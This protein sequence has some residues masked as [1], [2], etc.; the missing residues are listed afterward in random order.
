MCSEETRQKLWELIFDL[1]PPEEA[2]ALRGQ[3]TSDPAVARAYSEARLRA[4]L[5]AAA[6]KREE[7]KLPLD[8]PGA[9]DKFD[10]DDSPEVAAAKRASLVKVVSVLASLAALL[11]VSVGVFGFARFSAPWAAVAAKNEREELSNRYVRLKVT[12]S[13]T[14][15]PSTSNSISIDAM[16]LDGAPVSTELNVVVRDES[17][18][19]RFEEHSRTDDNGRANIAI[20]GDKVADN[21]VLNIETEGDEWSEKLHSDLYSLAQKSGDSSLAVSP[22]WYVARSLKDGGQP[23]EVD[24]RAPN[25]SSLVVTAQN[26]GKQVGQQA[27]TSN[28]DMDAS[29]STHLSLPLPAKVSGPTLLTF[30][31]S[32]ANP[33]TPLGERFF[34]VPSVH[35]LAILPIAPVDVYA[36]GDDFKLQFQV[37]GEGGQ[38][39]QA[40]LRVAV[41]EESEILAGERHAAARDNTFGFAF[42]KR[43]K[44]LADDETSNETVVLSY[45]APPVAPPLVLDN[46]AQVHT[47]YNQAVVEFDD[48][49]AARLRLFGQALLGGGSVLLVALVLLALLR[50]LRNARVLVPTLAAAAGCVLIG[51]IWMTARITDDGDLVTAVSSWGHGATRVPTDQMVA[52]NE[53]PP[54]SPPATRPAQKG[55]EFYRDKGDVPKD[56]TSDGP[57]PAKPSEPTPT[58]PAPA[59]PMETPAPAKETA[60][61]LPLG[62]KPE[63]TP[64]TATGGLGGYGGG[65]SGFAPGGLGGGGGRP[66]GSFSGGG[67]GGGQGGGGLGGGI[68]AP[69]GIPGPVTYLPR[70]DLAVPTVYA[71]ANLAT[72][73]DGRSVVSFKLPAKPGVYRIFIE[74]RSGERLGL[75]NGKITVRETPPAKREPASEPKPE[76]EPEE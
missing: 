64:A 23:V 48:R 29:K 33:P 27:I 52:N 25:S 70:E 35:K 54:M 58:S 66:G 32:T 28:D 5:L 68:G 61:D 67:P 24:V 55:I 69:G 4:E 76:P 46:T 1:L 8:V 18:A 31:D 14:M 13:Q 2:E 60:K 75:Y 26:G 38:P 10:L 17:G 21:G 62:K 34:Y 44:D 30:F 47:A 20:P 63:S 43:T 45:A 53:V 73:E 36:A 7:P 37:S 6:A 59:L 9:N 15:D 40:D 49:R 22:K 11:L 19:V 41:V 51:L 57:A 42:S 50:L 39:Q 71:D 12:R 72:G 56:F 16:A 3:I 74:G 65:T